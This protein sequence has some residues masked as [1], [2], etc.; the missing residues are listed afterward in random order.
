MFLTLDSLSHII[1][2][3]RIYV[4]VRHQL[5]KIC[6]GLSRVNKDLKNYLTLRF[7]FIITIQRKEMVPKK[8]D[9][10]LKGF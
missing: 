8:Y 3:K 7:R 2:S 10:F 1:Q 9:D 4:M 5:C 6:L